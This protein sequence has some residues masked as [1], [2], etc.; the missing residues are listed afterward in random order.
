MLML[1]SNQPF[2]STS[3]QRSQ[4]LFNVRCGGRNGAMV[5]CFQKLLLHCPEMTGV[6]ARSISCE[7]ETLWYVMYRWLREAFLF[8]QTN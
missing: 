4:S 2:I 6:A 7:K 8:T 5:G 3:Q 1:I